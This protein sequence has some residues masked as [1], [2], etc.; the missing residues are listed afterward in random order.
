MGKEFT[1]SSYKKASERARR[2]ALLLQLQL[3]TAAAADRARLL[4]ISPSPFPLPPPRS[5]S[6]GRP[7]QV[8][9]P[10]VRG[11]P[12]VHRGPLQ[13]Q[14]PQ[15]E[16]R[17]LCSVFV[18]L[19]FCAFAAVLHASTPLQ[20]SPRCFC[21]R[22]NPPPV[23]IRP[24]LPPATDRGVR[25]GGAGGRGGGGRGGATGV[26]EV[27][28]GE[29]A[30][31][32]GAVQLY[33]LA[34]FR[35]RRAAHSR[36]TCATPAPCQPTDPSRAPSTP[37]APIISLQ[38]QRR[39][40]RFQFKKGKGKKAADEDEEVSRRCFSR[41]GC[42]LSAGSAARAVDCALIHSP[43]SNPPAPAPAGTPSPRQQEAGGGGGAARGGLGAAALALSRHL[44]C[45]GEW[46][47]LGGGG[48]RRSGTRGGR[49]ARPAGRPVP[50]GESCGMLWLLCLARLR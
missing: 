27:Q 12:D 24:P 34:V 36:L 40:R 16:P 2:G 1:F 22:L 47:G 33:S 39:E 4:S 14:R 49:R 21:T 46:H 6:A 50:A 37:P 5:P 26:G 10:G 23:L 9:P 20:P 18:F 25:E 28:P 31:V 8:H 32:Q 3:L 35:L 48:R 15:R 45:Q 38:A 43:G 29:A 30:A 44:S 41:W 7:P 13:V 19:S 42:G 11:H 17:M